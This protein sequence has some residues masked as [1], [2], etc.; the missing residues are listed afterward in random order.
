MNLHA[1]IVSYLSGLRR[2]HCAQVE[3]QVNS[4]P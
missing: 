3:S 1:L 2:R 4:T